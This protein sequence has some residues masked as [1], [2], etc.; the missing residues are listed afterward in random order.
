MRQINLH[1]AEPFNNSP[2]LREMKVL[3]CQPMLHLLPVP[4]IVVVTSA[5]YKLLPQETI[6]SC[7][8]ELQMDG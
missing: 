1:A 2:T 7:T 8:L 5:K 4:V 6:L 3:P